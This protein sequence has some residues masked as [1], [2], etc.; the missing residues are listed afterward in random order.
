MSDEVEVNVLGTN[1]TLV[2]TDGNGV[3]DALE[4]SDGDG[5]SDGD[6]VNT[7]N[8]DPLSDDS[9]VSHSMYLQSPF[10]CTSPPK[11]HLHCFFT[12][13]GRRLER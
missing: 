9:D 13:S 3:S 10:L 11:T 2:D 4:D 7:H 6:E 12:Y 8:T 5:L 1:A